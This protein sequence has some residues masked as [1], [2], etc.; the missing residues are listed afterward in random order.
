MSKDR[1]VN[2]QKIRDLANH[3]LTLLTSGIGFAMYR[4]GK[5]KDSNLSVRLIFTSAPFAEQITLSGD[6]HPGPGVHGCVSDM[7]K[8]IGWFGSPKSVAYLCSKFLPAVWVPEAALDCL[9]DQAQQIRDDVSPDDDPDEKA[10]TARR[11]ELLDEAIEN[12]CDDGSEDDVC[13]S[14]EAYG[15]F[16]SEVFGDGPDDD[17]FTYAIDDG[18]WLV[19]IQRRFAECYQAQLAAAA[20]AQTAPLDATASV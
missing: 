8:G 9:K 2:E 15:E 12:A 20:P 6:I 14:C 5:P 18:E 11:L 3:E 17:G 10:E 7:G 13:R 19:A 1:Y 4:L 16:Y